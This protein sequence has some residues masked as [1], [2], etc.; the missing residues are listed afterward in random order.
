MII[1]EKIIFVLNVTIQIIQLKSANTHL[2]QNQM[3]VKE[4]KIKSQSSKT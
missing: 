2:I 3:S 4:D 1:T